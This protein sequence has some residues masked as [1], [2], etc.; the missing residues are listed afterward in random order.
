MELCL[1]TVQFGMAYG[2]NNKNGQPPLEKSLEMLNYASE[3]GISAFDT[4]AAYK[5]AEKIVGCFL[6]GVNTKNLRIISKLSPTCLNDKTWDVDAVVRGELK[7]SLEKLKIDCLY[8]YLLHN[9]DYLYND[10]L[11]ATLKQLK[12]EGLIKHYGVSIYDINDGF[13]GIAKGC[14]LIQ[15]PFSVFDQRILTQGLLDE[16]M[17][18]NV[19][20]HVRSTFLQGLLM[21]A[22]DQV[23]EKLS[24]LRP[25]VEKL[26]A[27]CE[28]Y[29]IDKKD[30]LIG[31][32][33]AT[34]GIH[35]LV[36]GVDNLQ[37]LQEFITIFNRV[38]IE[39]TAMQELHNS[40]K[41]IEEDLILPN[42]WSK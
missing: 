16:A 25:Y 7:S 20:I 2:I 1:G 6:G 29:D 38:N 13:S 28:C 32:V 36:F 5:E 22:P 18:K 37:Q 42:K 33:K 23:P 21:M 30:I 9:A 34:K 17:R 19:E 41:N 8:G 24:K 12:S 15:A 40:F 10:K 3:Q 4:A 26:N 31:F 39:K 35:S 14:T 27:I 11:M